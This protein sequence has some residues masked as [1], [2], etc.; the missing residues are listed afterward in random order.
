MSLPLDG[1]RVLSL[2]HQYP[3]PYATL[4]LADLG[5]DVVL[6]ER[7][8]AGDPARAFPGFHGA[9][10]RG[11]RSVALDLKTD[12]GRDL[13]RAL[14]R[15]SDVVLDGFRPGILDRLG[16][17]AR[18]LT[19]VRPD[20]VYV[21]VT[22]YGQGGPNETRPGHDLTYQAEAGMLYEHLP[23]AS[24]PAPPS[25]ALGDL[26]SGLLTVQAVLLGLLRRER[27][28][29]GGW[30]DVSMFDAL[31]SLL[32]AHIGPV[33]NK[34]GPPG[35]PYE[36]G[37]GVFA[38]RDG[39]YLALGVAHEDHFWRALCAATGL[40]GE[41]NLNARQRFD[42]HERLSAALAD[43]IATRTCAEW[44]EIFTAAD[45]PFGRVRGLGE[46]PDVP[47]VRA[48]KL[49]SR[50]PGDGR[51]YVRQPLGVD[52]RWP[53]PR[54]G[55]PGLGAHTVEVLA[56]TGVPQE[57]IDSAIASAAAIQHPGPG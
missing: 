19:E 45:V 23:P 24:P 9:L 33:L 31:V 37:Y 48:R 43:R 39:R 4:I 42:R 55:V 40:T 11:K 51:W 22:G 6:V 52:G 57:D 20:L 34:D 29:C 53:G 13:L 17:G 46:L 36:P 5:A 16:V 30:L 26:A 44:E 25:L 50:L 8:G 21:S 3:G 10:A 56:E 1:L 28:G 27:Q 47:H 41:L 49:I 32:T 18:E 38:T 54:S 15:R 7:P 12:Q 14:A 2:A 35:F